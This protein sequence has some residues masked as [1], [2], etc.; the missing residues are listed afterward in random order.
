[1]S[2]N[3]EPYFFHSNLSRN[4]KEK[5]FPFYYVQIAPFQYGRPLE[6]V[7]FR[8]SQRLAMSVPNTG[9]V[10]I[11]DIGNIRNIHPANKPDVGQRLANWALAKTYG[12]ENI[13][14]SGPLYRSK[15]IE[16]DKIRLFFDFAESGLVCKGEKLS[17]FEIA[18]SDKVFVEAEA[19]I[20]DGTV[21][22]WSKDIQKPAAVR[23]VWSNTAE[24]NLFN[25]AG[26]L[27]SCFRT[28]DW[29]INLDKSF[30]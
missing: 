5:N 26:L 25:K 15:G 10:V 17:L 19:K 3:I 30:K 27:A 29:E 28:D 16:G 8:E 1:M 6:G 20:D 14:Y 21:I 23:F 11:S 22:V 13:V 4:C 2:D 24:P 9:M 12:I 18:G 7:L